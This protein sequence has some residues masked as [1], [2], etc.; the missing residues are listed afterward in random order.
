M[1]ERADERASGEAEHTEDEQEVEQEDFRQR[2][3]QLGYYQILGDP[4]QAFMEALRQAGLDLEALK[5]AVLKF[6]REGDQ[7]TL[8][9]SREVTVGGVTFGRVVKGLLTEGALEKLEGV[10]GA[11]GRVARY[12]KP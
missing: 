11:E 2:A 7:F 4:A 9:L 3:A 8:E 6:E 10:Q 5:S 1:R 12:P